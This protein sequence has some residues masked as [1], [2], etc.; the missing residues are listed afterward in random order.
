MKG[1]SSRKRIK[2][3]PTD[4]TAGPAADGGIN[5]PGIA[6]IEGVGG[7]V[8]AASTRGVAGAAGG[9]GGADGRQFLQSGVDDGTDDWTSDGM[10]GSRAGN[11]VDAGVDDGAGGRVDDG[12]GEVEGGGMI[13]GGKVSRLDVPFDPEADGGRITENYELIL[14]EW[15]VP[16]IQQRLMRE[17]LRAGTAI[18][19]RSKEESDRCAERLADVKM[20]LAVLTPPSEIKRVLSKKWGINPRSV[21]AYMSVARAM[22]REYVGVDRKEAKANSLHFWSMDLQ[23]QQSSTVKLHKQMEEMQRMVGM[24]KGLLEET[25]RTEDQ[26]PLLNKAEEILERIGELQR[27]CRGLMLI[28]ERS[29]REIYDRIDRI[30]GNYAPMEHD[31]SGEI[32]QVVETR[33]SEPKTRKEAINRMVGVLSRN[34]DILLHVLTEIQNKIGPPALRQVL[35]RLPIVV[36]PR[37]LRSD[38]AG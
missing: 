18:D 36:E 9:A 2:G 35:S 25:E 3:T 5:A 12:G 21:E 15:G 24:V 1:N 31:V 20:L 23:R 28:A 32:R 11:R 22:L 33:R 30:L 14:D 17:R 26:L 16:Y 4:G 27:S 37:A 7:V 8:E 19:K 38:H 10:S 6:S 29:G 34:P 13:G